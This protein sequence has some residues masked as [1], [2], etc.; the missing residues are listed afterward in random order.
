MRI[1][2]MIHE[3]VELSNKSSFRHFRHGSVIVHK[4]KIVSWGFNLHSG[5]YL[6]YDQYVASCHAEI[7]SLNTLAHRGKMKDCTLVVV[8][9]NRKNVLSNSKPCEMCMARIRA[10]GIG[11]LIYSNSHDTLGIEWLR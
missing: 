5:R 4:N 10:S 11:K 9:T 1:K 8:R 3:C 6:K 2:D 7:M